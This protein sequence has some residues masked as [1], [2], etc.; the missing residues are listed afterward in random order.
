M[1]DHMCIQ[2]KVD[3]RELLFSSYETVGIIH[4]WF[5]SETT[6]QPQELLKHA[7]F[8]VLVSLLLGGAGCTDLHCANNC[9][10]VR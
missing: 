1:F 9:N 4:G 10:V 3:H 6:D 8:A 7:C 2:L 5:H